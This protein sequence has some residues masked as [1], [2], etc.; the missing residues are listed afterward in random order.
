M[1]KTHEILH[2]LL[3]LYIEFP[4]LKIAITDQPIKS[5]NF[6]DCL[7]IHLCSE[8]LLFDIEQNCVVYITAETLLALLIPMAG[9][10]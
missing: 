3:A 10:E 7:K 5:R 4:G 8:Q 6:S 1:S 9:D 2:L